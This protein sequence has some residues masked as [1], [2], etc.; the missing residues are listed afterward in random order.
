MS[1]A[2][3][4]RRDREGYRRHGGRMST[5]KSEIATRPI[6][7]DA[8]REALEAM[9]RLRQQLRK[10]ASSAEFARL[11]IEKQTPVISLQDSVDGDLMML[12]SY[13]RQLAERLDRI[14]HRANEEAA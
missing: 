1:V 2:R 11:P 9:L 3:G 14:M 10:F 7:D 13:H 12:S 6:D 5:A 4:G 8:A